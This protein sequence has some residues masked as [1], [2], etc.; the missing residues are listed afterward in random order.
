MISRY[1]TR[2]GISSRTDEGRKSTRRV[3]IVFFTRPGFA[4]ILSPLGLLPQSV[5]LAIWNLAKAAIDLF[6][7]QAIGKKILEE[8]AGTGK[9]MVL[10][11]AL[12]IAA[13]GFVLLARPLAH[14]FSI[15]SGQ[16]YSSSREASG[17]F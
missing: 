16:H 4:W 8:S 15:R 17:R 14:R 5:A 9:R 6:L 12:A 11:D 1:F 3:R 13:G 2:H 7:I 10:E